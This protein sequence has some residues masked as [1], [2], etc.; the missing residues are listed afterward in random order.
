MKDPTLLATGGYGAGSQISGKAVRSAASLARW[1][2]V[3]GKTG[4][5]LYRLA[6]WFCPSLVLE[7]GTGLGISTSYLATGAVD[8]RVI[9]VEANREKAN[10]ARAWIHSMGLVNVE[11]VQGLFEES[12]KHIP[13]FNDDRVIIFLDGNH[14]YKPTISCL[15]QFLKLESKEIMIILDDIHWSKEMEQAWKEGREMERVDGS[16]D[17]FFVG[18][19]LVKP[20]M[21][22]EHIA[23]SW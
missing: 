4:R 11:I 13:D 19:L 20:G 1:S 18:I 3:S 16:L 5:L 9:S 15:N 2:S 8:A 6:A 21:S 14:L 12:L 10:Y 17:L 22:R 7:F 23:V